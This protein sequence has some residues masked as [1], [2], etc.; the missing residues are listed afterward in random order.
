MILKRIALLSLLALIGFQ[1]F[2]DKLTNIPQTVTQP[3]GSVFHCLGSGDEFYHYLHDAN[4]YTIV[5]NPA[6]GFFYYGKRV[7]E[8][9]VPSSYRVGSVDPASTG[10]PPYAR[11]SKRLYQDR[12]EAYLAPM[13]MKGMDDAPTTGQVNQ[14]SIY[15]SFAD[16]SVYATPRQAYFDDYSAMGQRSLKD[17]FHEVSYDRLFVDTYHFPVSPDTINVTYIAEHPRAYYMPYSAANP[18]GY[19]DGQKGGREHTLLK[20][21]CE[22]IASQV[23]DSIDLDANNDGR[24]DNVCFTLK[25]GTTAWSTL[26][27]P[28]R[29]ALYNTEAT[30]KGLRVWDYLFML[31]E[32]FN[33]ATLC[34]EFFHV[35]GAPDLYHYTDTGA[36]TACGPWDIMDQSGSH[37]YMCAFMKY[38]YGDW[39]ATLPEIRESGSYSIYPLQ[40]PDN[41]IWKIKSPLDPS[42]YFVVEYRK[43]E[44][45]YESNIPGEGLVVYRINPDAGRG[46]A[47]GPPDEIYVYRAG[48]TLTAQGSF[49]EAPLGENRTAMN[50]G[51]DPS[52][53]LYNGGK[54]GKG[55]LDLFNVVNHGDSITFDVNIEVMHPPVDLTFT[56]SDGQVDLDWLPLYVTGFQNYVV[57]KNGERLATTGASQFTDE[58]IYQDS[59]YNFYV[60]ASYT[61]ENEGESVPSNTISFTPKG[62]MSVPYFEDFEDAGHGW[63]IAGN[64]NGFRWGDAA[65]HEMDTDNETLFL[66]ANSFATG[67]G[68]NTRDMAITPRL[69]LADYSSATLEFDYT[70]RRLSSTDFL[71]VWVRRSATDGWI[72]L[73][74]LG[75]SAFGPRFLWRTF[76]IN[77]PADI[78]TTGIQVGFQYNDAEESSYGTG[79]DNISITGIRTSVSQLT[80]DTNIQVYP[81][82]STGQFTIQFSALSGD[83]QISVH[84]VQGALIHS[85][86]F[87]GNADKVS[88]NM[89]LSSYADGLYYLLIHHDN[90][91]SSRKL[92]KQTLR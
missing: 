86:L 4:G 29:W 19:T 85:Q 13:R 34:H 64:V 42:E 74:K 91:L 1:A 55:G 41:N 2:A 54:G 62:I 17:Y 77:L 90:E 47:G 78:L 36:P 71:K 7:D 60:T 66:A 49:S 92:L 6:D 43:R 28:H 32:G 80:L 53:F 72:E 50:D 30:I 84:D 14:L 79:I 33:V 73:R 23:P 44:G 40:N 31:E 89:D 57:Y 52:S 5:M 27:W 59:T 65:L 70:L 26:L 75:V 20:K 48:G 87:T 81:N 82:P 67:H 56:L 24:V 46:N 35:L 3:D 63:S 39:M 37:N 68:A 76:K 12:K 38:K 69:D 45:I 10:L 9:V 83:A 16:D 11:I 22:F 58:E 18:Q 8:D 15:I 21:A 25:G 61:G 88:I 51:T